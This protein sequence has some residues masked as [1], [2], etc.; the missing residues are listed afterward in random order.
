[1]GCVIS[2]GAALQVGVELPSTE[3]AGRVALSVAANMAQKAQERLEEAQEDAQQAVSV[4]VGLADAPE[5]HSD[6]KTEDEHG[7][8]LSTLWDLPMAQ[9][10]RL[11]GP[12]RNRL[13]TSDHDVLQQQ[14]PILRTANESWALQQETSLCWVSMKWHVYMQ[15]GEW[16]RWQTLR[17]V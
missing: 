4:A 17:R 13:S 10:E 6:K 8:A 12:N 14:R 9:L 5:E 16:L 7:K 2:H 1:M 15:R 11:K 3:V